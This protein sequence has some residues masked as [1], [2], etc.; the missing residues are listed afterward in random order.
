M[1]DWSNLERV[2]IDQ[3]RRYVLSTVGKNTTRAETREID[4]LPME[5]MSSPHAGPHAICDAM[6]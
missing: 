5:L 6:M 2:T 3:R 1:G 4:K